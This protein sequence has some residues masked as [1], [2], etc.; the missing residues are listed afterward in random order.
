MEVEEIFNNIKEASKFANKE[1]GQNYLIDQKIAKE[2]VDILSINKKDNVLEIGA[3]FGALSIFLLSSPYK[4]LTLNDIDPRGLSFLD[5]LVEHAHR[6]YVINKSALKLDASVYNKIIGNLPYYITNDLLEHYFCKCN[7]DKY[8][9]MI[10]KEVFERINAKPNTNNYG[11]LSILTSVIG[12]I[13]KEK[14][15]DKKCFLPSPH[16]D[17]LVFSLTKNKKLTIDKYKFLLF[18]KKMFI[19]RRKTIYNNLSLY[20]M[21]K[22][23]A[24]KILDQIKLSL[25]TRPEAIDEKTYLNIFMLTI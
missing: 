11:P 12:E 17:S 14:L 6:A 16:I 18:L 4:T 9:F 15:V 1:I 3:G 5:N 21:D 13:K 25:L 19:H 8:V 24:K 20:L 23:K 7:A 2:I 10:Q 22:N